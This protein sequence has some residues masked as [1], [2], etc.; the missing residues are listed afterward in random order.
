MGQLFYPF[1]GMMEGKGMEKGHQ[2]LGYFGMGKDS[3][4]NITGKIKGPAFNGERILVKCPSWLKVQRYRM[5]LIISKIS[6]S[7][8]QIR[9]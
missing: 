5:L 2:P 6:G 7:G 4:E 9:L 1:L 8:I 3:E